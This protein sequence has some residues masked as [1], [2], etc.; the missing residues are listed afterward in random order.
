MVIGRYLNLIDLIISSE[1]KLL[2]LLLLHNLP[3]S[4][5]IFIIAIKQKPNLF[6]VLKAEYKHKV[7]II[8]KIIS[9]KYLLR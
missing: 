2:K 5:S 6:Q 8:S 4:S 3:I 7:I 1:V 9:R